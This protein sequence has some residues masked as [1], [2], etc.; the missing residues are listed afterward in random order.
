MNPIK[1][2]KLA[3]ITPS[4]V[5]VAVAFPGPA[6]AQDGGQKCSNATL[7]GDYGLHAT[8]IRPALPPAGM[9]QPE[10][11]ATIAIRTY[12][13]RGNFTGI[14]VLTNGQVSGVSAGRPTSGTYQVNDDCSGTVTIN[15]PGV[16]A[17]IKSAFVIV[18]KGAEI[19]ETPMT[20]GEIGIAI[21]QRM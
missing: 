12:D 6:A 21:L 8:G 9:G 18:N 19:K 17:A 3:I 7:K 1:Y 14:G 11:H 5:F 2:K 15:I 20:P 4:L 16:P 10:M 13:G